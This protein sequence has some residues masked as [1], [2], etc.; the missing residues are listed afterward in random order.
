MTDT[1]RILTIL[2]LVVG[3]TSAAADSSLLVRTRSSGFWSAPGTWETG[4]VPTAQARVQ[5][6][7]GHVVVYDLATGPVV[8]SI[9]VA[10]VLR[11]ATDRDTQLDVGLIKIE[12]GEDASETGL[13]ADV[14]RGGAAE[15]ADCA[16]EI[17]APD[18]PLPASR[19][20]VI[21]LTPC[22]GLDPD[23][24]P[25]IISRGGRVDLHGAPLSRTWVK[26][27]ETAARGA[28]RI[29]LAE[30]VEGWRAG[31]RVIVTATRRQRIADSSDLPSVRQAG[32][33]EE[34]RIKSLSGLEIELDAPLEFDHEGVKKTRGEVANL[35]RNVVVE[36]ADKATGRGHTMFHRGSRAAIS[37]VEFRH[38]GKVDTLGRYSLHFHKAGDSMRGSSV[39]GA[40]LWDSG[41]RWI[42]I[43]G[44]NRLVI[45]DCVGY[46]SV[47]HGFFL[48]D[49]TEV[50]NVLDG[51]LAVQ[52]CRGKP[53]PGQALPY[54]RNEGAGF[55][56]ADNRNAF[57]RNVAVE[58][59][60]YGFRYE[61]E[62]EGGFDPVLR[63]RG[64]DGAR[65]PVDVRVLPFLRFD[66]N[67][68]HSQRR[69]GLNLGGGAGDGGSGGVGV[70]PDSRHPLV[71]RRFKVWDA[72]W[73][74][75][76]GAPGTL[77]DGLDVSG[78]DFG[79]W[80]PRYERLAYRGLEIYRT[81]WAFFA[82]AGER[83]NLVKYPEPLDPIDDR[84]PVTAITSARVSGV[85][86]IVVRGVS[87]D[88]G[89]VAAVV[90]NGRPAQ[91]TAADF[92]QWE[93]TLERPRKSPLI[94]SAAAR[95]AAG[96]LERT[97]HRTAVSF[98][99]QDPPKAPLPRPI[100]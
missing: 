3:S 49:G 40:S 78:S 88:D 73:A 100:P 97:P 27:G 45:R 82:E 12:P 4:S 22:P 21:R 53:L 24:T 95:D 39:V 38:L 81:K 66:D 35:S 76:L 48:E 47:G 15:A 50:D 67:E 68:A 55:W 37:F 28:S 86:S 25:A 17:G 80:R 93:I 57:M 64:S 46:R 65:R 89:A 98:S 23:L 29:A 32:Q 59:D 83:P 6:R 85:G 61:I 13:E 87:V 44:T 74:I 42:T 8:R 11:F 71:I 41:N 16:L 31:D 9:H 7:P 90:V 5:V 51:C 43:H 52:A 19:R 20:A 1:P 69:Y 72:H 91:P 75:T 60:Q 54:D 94:L 33:T 10:G 92:S 99:D 18:E 14:H 79:L 84:P 36:S 62:P 70:G 56:W 26:L 77:V 2:A 96:N 63:V 34:R 58:C 30:P